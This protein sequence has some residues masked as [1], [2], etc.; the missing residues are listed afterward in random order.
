MGLGGSANKIPFLV[1]NGVNN[2]I[3]E[4]FYIFYSCVFMEYLFKNKMI[5]LQMCLKNQ[6]N[7]KATYFK[8]DF[9]SS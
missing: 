8:N 5:I 4:H 2:F 6:Q 9:A 3:K 7:I 1:R